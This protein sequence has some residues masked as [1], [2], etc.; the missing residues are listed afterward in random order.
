MKRIFWLIFAIMPLAMMAQSPDVVIDNDT[1]KVT[2]LAELV[3]EG[4]TQQVIKNGVEY[5]P[6]K[7]MKNSSV[8]ATQLLVNLQAPQLRINMS[9]REIKTFTGQD[10]A[11]FINYRKATS[12]ELKG[13]R[14]DDVIKVEVL[15]YPEDP[16]FLG[17]LNVVNFVVH[18][19]EYGGFTK[20]ILDA[21][22]YD[23]DA[24]IGV[25]YSKFNYKNWKFNLSTMDGGTRSKNM[26]YYSEEKFKDITFQ[27]KHYDELTRISDAGE[28]FLRKGNLENVNFKADWSNN[29][30]ITAV[31]TFHFDRLAGDPLYQRTSRL[32]YSDPSLPE[33]W[34]SYRENL[35]NINYSA[36]G[37]YIFQL[38]KSYRLY[39]EWIFGYASNRRDSRDVLGDFSE[40]V[41]DSREKIYKYAG[42]I[43][44]SKSFNHNNRLSL[45]LNTS[46]NDYKTHY[47]RPNGEMQKLLSS[48]ATANLTYTQGWN[49]G[50]SL[51]ART[52]IYYV[53]GKI[54]GK[55]KISRLNPSIDIEWDYSISPKHS[56]SVSAWWLNDSPQSDL[57]NDAFVQRNELVWVKGN[58][59][60]KVQSNTRGNVTYTFIPTN[61]LSMNAGLTYF[62]AYNK[63]NAFYTTM[64]GY[65]GLVRNTE[66]GGRYSKYVIDLSVTKRLFNSLTLS[67]WGTVQWLDMTGINALKKTL[68]NAELSVGYSL[69]RFYINGSYSIPY[70]WIDYTAMGVMT[71]GQS[72]YS[73]SVTYNVG[74]FIASIQANNIFNSLENM[75]TTFVSHNY[76][77]TVRE[78][79]EG[80]GRKIELVLSYTI[81]YG[82][83]VSRQE[84]VG[85]GENLNSAVLK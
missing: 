29:K 82:K 80:F 7:K 27:G 58:P 8:D 10:V 55:R 83:K 75:R 68:Y 74:D 48:S 12:D 65:D 52:G 77:Q 15:Q 13:M 64:P 16:R 6:S 53:Y 3:V 9:T 57:F 73:L 19:Y 44:L 63:V 66:S 26:P 79:N 22:A 43:Q 23:V 39:A 21:Q 24:L 31:H 25:V 35:Q 14:T 1:T 61:T 38:P 71:H 20:A 76:S 50:M 34:S 81:P 42:V 4:R 30:N 40:I 54:N 69:G 78:W 17:E 51:Y 49:N 62:S 72:N 47:I 33:D 84:E 59:N 11:F 37:Y 85:K 46:N 18:E 36:D 32:T 41:N 5:I 28:G 60:L 56:L 2:D 67:A 45:R 70:N